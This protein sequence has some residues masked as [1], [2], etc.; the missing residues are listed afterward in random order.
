MNEFSRQN[1]NPKP[2]QQPPDPQPHPTGDITF[3]HGLSAADVLVLD[4]PGGG[5][6]IQTTP[7]LKLP[8]KTRHPGQKRIHRRA[9]VCRCTA[10]G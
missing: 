4:D 5:N 6:V 2:A 8:G 1:A 3:T 10:S 9:F 7:D